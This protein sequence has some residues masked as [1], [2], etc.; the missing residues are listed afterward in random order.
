MYHIE[1][2]MSLT[3]NYIFGT[4]SVSIPTRPE[5]HI[6]ASVYSQLR[7]VG[8]KGAF[9]PPAGFVQGPQTPGGSWVALDTRAGPQGPVS[10]Q[11]QMGLIGDLPPSSERQL[12]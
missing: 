6:S 11:A 4:T 9:R 1:T 2:I 10:I 7:P 12:S 5:G 8:A 3:G